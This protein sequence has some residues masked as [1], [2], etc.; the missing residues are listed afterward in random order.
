MVVDLDDQ[1][2]GGD[3]LFHFE[4]WSLEQDEFAEVIR[5]A[6]ETGCLSSNPVEV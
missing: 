1:D 3:P 4:K 2:Q 6:W 5:K